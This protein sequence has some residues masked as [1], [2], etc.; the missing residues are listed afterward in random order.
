MSTGSLARLRARLDP[1]WER[2]RRDTLVLLVAT[3]LSTA[4]HLA[5]LPV[6]TSAGFVALFAWRLALLLAGRPLPSDLVRWMAAAC[7]AAAV[8]AQYGTVLGSDPGVALLVLTMGLKLLELRARRDLFV[9]IFLGFFLLLTGF[10]HSQSIAAGALTLAAVVALLVAMQT[11][12]F[13]GRQP[14]MGRRIRLASVLLLQ[15]LPIAAMLFLLFPRI[16]GPLWRMPLDASRG[17]T[18]LSDSMTPGQIASLIESDEVAFRVRF[19]G[20]APQRAQLYWRGPVLGHFD[21][22]TWRQ[23][24]LRTPQGA[25]PTVAGGSPEA[26]RYTVTLEP[27]GRPWLLALEVP[28]RVVEAPASGAATTAEMLLVARERVVQRL[29]YTLESDTAY[30]L[31]PDESPATLGRYLQLPPGANPQAVALAR[32]WRAAQVSDEAQV[33]QALVNQALRHFGAEAF[34]YTLEPP[35]LGRDAVDDFL[36]RTRAG[37]CEHYAG[38]FVVLARAMGIPA[39]VVTGYLG[40]E[41]NPFDDVWTVRQSDAHAW[42]EVWLAERGWVRVD[43]TAAIDPSRVAPGV[44]SLRTGTNDGAAGA[45]WFLR[46]R[47]GIDAVANAW[48][49]WVLV[50]DAG[51]Q[52]RLLA[53]LGLEG[54]DWRTSVGLLA[55]GIATCVGAI[56]LLTLRVRRAPEP[57]VRSYELFCR[58]LAKRGVV[59]RPNETPR[60]LLARARPALDAASMREAERIV[61]LYDALRYAKPTPTRPERVRHLRELVLAFRP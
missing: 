47:F 16:T 13:S 26:L 40:G 51:R 54:A 11:V 17:V 61:E 33:N 27:N 22:R 23:S 49:Q 24:T 38:A 52:E 58:R 1:R 8:L 60:A 28:V 48:N 25:G 45:G 42:A 31:A 10:F 12:Q 29:R 41:R 7:C 34:R 44:R 50:Y 35:A 57:E 14:S 3:L 37:F 43:P 32:S 9:V 55:A 5:Q 46:I 6:W 2:E 30:R 15:A 21:G 19:E 56:A 39:R 4:P 36:F 20:P 53:R 59:R 18:G